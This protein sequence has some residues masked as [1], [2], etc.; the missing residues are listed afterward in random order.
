LGWASHLIEEL[1]KGN[2]VTCHPRG[3]SMTPLI[4]SGEEVT[5]EPVRRPVQRDD[6]VLCKVRGNQFLHKVTAVQ[7]RQYQ[8]SN[9]HGHVNGWCTLD[10]IFGLMVR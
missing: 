2:T 1:K 6:I 8:I 9:N 4:K 3:H 10:Q 7:G 5:I